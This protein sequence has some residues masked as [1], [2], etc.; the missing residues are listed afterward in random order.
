MTH[1]TTTWMLILTFCNVLHHHFAL[2]GIKFN[3]IDYTLMFVT[4]WLNLCK[5]EFTILY[6]TKRDNK[7]FTTLYYISSVTA[8]HSSPRPEPRDNPHYRHTRTG[9]PD[10]MELRWLYCYQLGMVSLHT[11][12]L[13]ISNQEKLTCKSIFV[14]SWPMVGIPSHKGGEL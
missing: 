5:L 7:V 3:R 9:Q 6:V 11:Y 4:M 1:F 14:Q 8:Y 13:S 10:R 2:I 12:T